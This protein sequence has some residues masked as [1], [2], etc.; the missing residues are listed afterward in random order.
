MMATL[1]TGSEQPKCSGATMTGTLTPCSENTSFRRCAEPS[2]SAATTTCHLSAM[3]SRILFAVPSASPVTGPQPVDGIVGASK[4]SEGRDIEIARMEEAPSNS[5]S[6]S[7]CKRGNDLSASRAHVDASARA[8]SSS[9]ASK[10]CAR[11][12]MRFGSTNNNSLSFGKISV[13]NSSSVISQGNQLSMPS[14]LAPSDNLSQCS[15]PQASVATSDRA[16][17]FTS[18]VICNSRAG[19]I[20]ATSIASVL[21]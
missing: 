13:S 15:R 19:K 20:V 2:P 6:T 21:R 1:L 9:S 10:S 14:K 17:S 16:M 7:A 3:S 11:V 18:S 5:R 12:R 4:A 8:K